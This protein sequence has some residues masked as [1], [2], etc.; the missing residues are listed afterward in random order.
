MRLRVLIPLLVFALIAGA[1]YAGL[2]LRPREIPSALI[3]KPVP[4]FELPPVEGRAQG[5]STADLTKGEPSLVNVFASWCAPCRIEH[6]VWVELAKKGEVP[7][8]GL[9][10]KDQPQA[11][12]RWLETFGDPYTRTGVYGAPET[13]VV[14]GDGTIVCKY[15]S[16]VTREMLEEKILPML[17]DL[18][19]TG[20]TSRSC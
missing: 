6:P 19:Q 10:W 7:I 8:H 15:I 13:F 1:L 9:N 11:A 2:S 18:K 14:A 20:K 5:L 16:V 17:R 12:S 3:G 4:S